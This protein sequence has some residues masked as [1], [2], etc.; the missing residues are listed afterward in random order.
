MSALFFSRA[1]ASWA[2]TRGQKNSD[3]SSYLSHLK[4]Y[5]S[6]NLNLAMKLKNKIYKFI[7]KFGRWPWAD[8]QNKLRQFL[9]IAIFYIK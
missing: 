5:W 3:L 8:Q 7:K 4:R 2:G 1:R 6:G 9:P